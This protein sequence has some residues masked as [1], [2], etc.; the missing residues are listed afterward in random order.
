M[1]WYGEKNIGKRFTPG[2]RLSLAPVALFAGTSDAATYVVKAHPTANVSFCL[3]PLRVFHI[4]QAPFLLYSLP[5]PLLP[6]REGL[7]RCCR[8]HLIPDR[9]QGRRRRAPSPRSTARCPRCDEL[10]PL[11]SE[12]NAQSLYCNGL[13]P[14]GAGTFQSRCCARQAPALLPAAAGAGPGKGDVLGTDA[15]TGDL[16]CWH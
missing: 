1:H 11:A 6:T 7:C 12:S 8:A 5:R 16:F 4:P 15:T 9:R 14:S 3:I 13:R 10:F 2:D